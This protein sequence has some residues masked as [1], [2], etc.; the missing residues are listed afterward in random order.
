MAPRAACLEGAPSTG[1]DT[2]RGCGRGSCLGG[3][4]REPP[5][6]V[7]DSAVLA[8]VREHWSADIDGV[9]HLPVGFGAHHWVGVG[10][11][12]AGLLPDA[13]RSRPAPRRGLARGGVRRGV[14]LMFPL[15]FVVAPVP[16][17]AGTLTVAVRRR[18]A[19]SDGLGRRQQPRA[20]RPGGRRRTCCAGCTPSHHRRAPEVDDDHA[21]IAARRPGRALAPVGRRSLRRAGPRRLRGRLDAIAGWSDTYHGLAEVA[22]RR[23]GWSPTASPASTT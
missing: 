9:E 3:R 5:V 16:S 23:P 11:R 19:L 13:R 17:A 15:D 6:D 12:P 20:G 1:A 10:A 21:A 2:P 4:V 14:G 7:S 8:A 18:R 22:Q